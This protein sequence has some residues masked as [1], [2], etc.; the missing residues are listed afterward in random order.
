MLSKLIFHIFQHSQ[1][2]DSLADEFKSAL[3]TPMLA[4]KVGIIVAM[5]IGGVLLFVAVGLLIVV[6]S[7]S[8]VSINVLFMGLWV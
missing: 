5:V 3:K 4:I 7:K 8:S 2:T 1:I 6:K